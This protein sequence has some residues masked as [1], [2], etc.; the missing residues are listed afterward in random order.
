MM[1][2]TVDSFLS[3]FVERSPYYVGT[4][5]ED[6]P[7]IQGYRAKTRHSQGGYIVL[8]RW[9]HRRHTAAMELLQA[10]VDRALIALWLGHESVETTQIYLDADLALKEKVLAKTTPIKGRRGSYRPDD[11]LLGFLK[12]L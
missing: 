11:Q 3:A 6:W 9:R 10:G 8:C 5:D 2:L 4:S 12:S 7:E 1:Y